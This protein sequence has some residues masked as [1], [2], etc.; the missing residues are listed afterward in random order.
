MSTPWRQ[1]RT[2]D[3]WKTCILLKYLFGLYRGMIKHKCPPQ[4]TDII[5]RYCVC[6]VGWLGTKSLQVKKSHYWDWKGYS[7]QKPGRSVECDRILVSL[8]SANQFLTCDVSIS[9]A[10][11][12]SCSWVGKSV[13]ISVASNLVPSSTSLVLPWSSTWLNSEYSS[14]SSGPLSWLSLRRL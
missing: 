1:Q 7:S 5:V 3:E 4:C 2:A 11:S 12:P 8:F 10:L 13:G 14:D 9:A 6:M